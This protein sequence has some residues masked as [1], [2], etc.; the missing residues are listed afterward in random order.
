MLCYVLPCHPFAARVVFRDMHG[1]QE[2]G[3]HTQTHA[4]ESSNTRLQPRQCHACILWWAR[5]GDV[6]C[7][8]SR[9]GTTG[10]PRTSSVTEI[11]G[12]LTGLT[13]SDAA[14]LLFSVLPAT[15]G[16]PTV[17]FAESLSLVTPSTPPELP[18]TWMFPVVPS[19]CD[20]Q[21]QTNPLSALSGPAHP[22]RH[23]KCQPGTQHA[24]HRQGHKGTRF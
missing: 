10:Q 11:A 19:A 13:G 16:I 5:P 17:G 8:C 6:W 1:T 24:R 14:H 15:R 2:E 4:G 22:V 18:V 9:R 23:H 20:S 3:I 12:H 21:L 7:A